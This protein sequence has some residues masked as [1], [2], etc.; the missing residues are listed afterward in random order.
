MRRVSVAAT[1]A[2]ATMAFPVS[3]DAGHRFKL[4]VSQAKKEIE[5]L[6]K[7]V[8]ELMP[9]ADEY[10]WR[11][12]PCER[13][14]RLKVACKSRVS[15]KPPK[16]RCKSVEVIAVGARHVDEVI[17]VGAARHVHSDYRL[18]IAERRTISRECQATS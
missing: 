8:A 13:L 12:G 7:A 3:A 6:D 10:K 2:V 17:A 5:R 15:W 4:P 1:V 14:G 11:V 18:F 16:E 9:I